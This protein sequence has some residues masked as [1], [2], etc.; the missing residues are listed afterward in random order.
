MAAQEA[1]ARDPLTGL[2][3]RLGLERSAQ[4][5]LEGTASKGKVPWLVLVDVDWFKDVNDDAGH[6]AGDAALAGDRRLLRRECRSDDL[7]ARWA[8]DEFVV[9]LRRRRS[10]HRSRSRRRRAHPGRRRPP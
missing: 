10:Q 1:A 8:G 7:V 2:A 3:N 9:L 6:A 5:L 4:Q